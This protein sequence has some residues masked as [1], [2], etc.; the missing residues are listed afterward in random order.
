MANG[1]LTNAMR[2]V[3]IGLAIVFF[4][5]LIKYTMVFFYDVLNAPRMVHLKVMLPR[6]D[7]KADREQSKEISKDMKEKIGRMAQVYTNLHKLGDLS[8]GD[9]LL[10]SLF[11]KPKVSLMLHY[12]DGQ[13]YFIMS[14]YPEYVD[15]LEGA[16]SAQFSDV[17]L[18]AIE[19]P[20]MFG[21]KH[22]YLV[23]LHPKKESIYPIRMFNQMHDDPLNNLVDSMSKVKDHDTFTLLMPIKPV[24]SNFN[25]KAKRFSD[26]LYKKDM[27]A[28]HKTP[29]Y[30]YILMPRKL[31]SFL[32][33]G[34]SE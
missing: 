15:I 22:S 14:T 6:G 3:L 10:Y 5:K 27:S 11:D 1:R 29:W 33:K 12:E 13:L 24:S 20:K 26:A 30:L 25:K 16:L 4:W 17:S 7:N 34:P 19:K 31:L 28:L 32:T 23:P 2:V 18:E 8:I 21:K 9:S